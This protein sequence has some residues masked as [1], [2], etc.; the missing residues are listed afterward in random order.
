MAVNVSAREFWDEKFLEG[1]SA[2]LGE[3]GLDPGLLVLEVTERVLMRDAEA[4]TS[5]L[6]ALRERGVQVAIDNLG[7]DYLR[8][9]YLQKFPVGALK[10][11]QSFVHQISNPDEDPA[12]VTALID[13]AHRLKLRVVAEGVETLEQLEFLQA[14]RCDEAQGEYFSRPLPS[15][16]FAKLLS[17]GIPAPVSLVH[18]PLVAT[19]QSDRRSRGES[20]KRR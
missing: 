15:E 18:R 5:T 13:M 16:Q 19:P 9:S 8:L 7:T 6:Q 3:T 2:I 1:I 10:I 14:N 20:A 17:T 4:A 11:D 12:I